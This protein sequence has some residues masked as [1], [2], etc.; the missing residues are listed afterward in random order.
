VAQ[1]LGYSATDGALAPGGDLDVSLFWRALDGLPAAGDWSVF[2][3]LLDAQGQVV[4][5]WEGPPVAWHPTSAWQ[6]GELERSQHTLRLPA[7]L[8]DGRYQLIAGMFA[9]AT[10]R[11]LAVE[12]GGLSRAQDFVPLEWVEVAG[13][14]HVMQA[15]RPQVATEAVLARVG[16]LV[17]YDLDASR[18]APGQ[19]LPIT[20]YWQATEATGDRLKVFVHL[21]DPQGNIVAQ[22]DA[23]P[24]DGTYPT[25]S[26]LP[27]E[28]LADKHLLTVP[29]DA[30]PGPASV[31]IGLYDPH[32]RQRVPWVD[33]AGQVA[34]DQLPL[35]ALVEVQ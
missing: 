13:R 19:Q 28:Y 20:L 26:W 9:P 18:V 16:R 21:L 6:P 30:R 4:A 5:A 1:L 10:D 34:G 7:T 14:E 22:S 8:A 24:G 3:Q 12:P 27:G 33:S 32:T 15:P 31:V 23:E 2:V 25:S 17:G 29:E 35:P 11:R